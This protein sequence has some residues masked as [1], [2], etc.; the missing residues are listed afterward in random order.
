VLYNTVWE[1]YAHTLTA[2]FATAGALVLGVSA[3]QVLRN[4]DG[5][6][7]ARSAQFAAGF[8]LVW[9]V[10]TMIVGDAQARLMDEQQPM[11][12]A[13]AEALYNTTKAPVSRF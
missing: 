1:A 8:T 3:W 10:A 9:L 5:A 6:S 12:M 4:R 11:K 7:F 2:A 13:A